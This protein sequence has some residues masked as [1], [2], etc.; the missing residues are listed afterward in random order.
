MR[1]REQEKSRALDI[2]HTE[3][4]REG[5]V[6]TGVTGDSS[7]NTQAHGRHVNLFTCALCICLVVSDRARR[8]R[9][10]QR[11]ELTANINTLNLPEVVRLT[12]SR[13]I[14]SNVG[15]DLFSLYI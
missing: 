3:R 11:T 12:I 9:K 4:E 13:Y 2:R 1:E 8:S 5:S 15:N 7:V 6:V 10:G 14:W